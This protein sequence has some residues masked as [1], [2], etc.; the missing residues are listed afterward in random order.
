MESFW[1]IDGELDRFIT[2]ESF[3]IWEGVEQ[4]LCAEL[5]FA[6]AFLKCFEHSFDIYESSDE[7]KGVTFLSYLNIL[8]KWNLFNIK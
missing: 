8:W 1:E 2:N 4:N 7:E 6:F 5:T 3:W